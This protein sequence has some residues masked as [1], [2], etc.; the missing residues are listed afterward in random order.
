V[1]E[2]KRAET[3]ARRADRAAEML[4]ARVRHP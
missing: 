4:R 2:A 3:R 1:G